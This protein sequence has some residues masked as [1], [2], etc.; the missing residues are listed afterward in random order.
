MSKTHNF[1]K[2]INYIPIVATA[3]VGVVL[4]IL[5]IVMLAG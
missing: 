1:E 2:R 5:G 4:I 3:M